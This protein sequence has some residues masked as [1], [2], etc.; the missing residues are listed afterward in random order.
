MKAYKYLIIGGGM[1]GDAAAKSIRKYDQQAE[2]GII[3]AEIHPPYKRPPLTKDLWKDKEFNSIWLKTEEKMVDVILDTRIVDLDLNTK[4]VKD[5]EGNEYGYEKL[6]LATGG[7]VR[8]LPFGSDHI[9]YYRYSTDFLT[10][11]REAETKDHFTVIGGSFIGSE[12]AAGL[13]MNGKDVT[14]L[15][16]EQGI[17]ANIFPP[18]LSEYI[19][20][21]YRDKGVKVLSGELAQA[22]ERD[23]ERWKLS[24]ES[25]EILTDFVVAGIGIQP[26]TSLAVNA[27]LK[28]DD[29][30]VVDE[31]LRT[32]QPEVYAAG[33]VATIYNTI[34]GR[35]IRYEHEDN[36][37]KM[38][39]HAGK[40]MVG[41]AAR[42]D[43]YLPFFYSDLFDLGYEAVGVLDARLETLVDW[44]EKYK[45]GVVYYHDGGKVEGVLLWNVWGALDDARKII[46]NTH[47][48][49]VDPVDLLGKI[50]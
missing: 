19:S 38:G 27:G 46:K 17:C 25:S 30:V 3:S 28:V 31:Y 15:F 1:T 9:L 6:L 8:R 13:R 48:N 29:G 24:T 36:A 41:R 10:L 4:R 2:I 26:N 34:L 45:K 44:Q 40:N 47:E 16:P 43:E 20:D 11:K 7:S 35:H 21:Y 14:M 18:D 23:N 42:Y 22:V 37:V 49:P 5:D 39:T 12:I 50:T 32:S 33:D